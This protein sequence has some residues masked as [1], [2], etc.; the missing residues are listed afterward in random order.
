M[1]GVMQC[2]KEFVPFIIILGSNDGLVHFWKSGEMCRSLDHLFSVSLV[3][4]GL[5]TIMAVEVRLTIYTLLYRLDSS[6]DSV[7]QSLVIS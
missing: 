2:L 6:M 4:T 7:F 3:S 5:P 1:T